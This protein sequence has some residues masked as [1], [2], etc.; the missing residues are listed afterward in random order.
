[1]V[2]DVEA[3]LRGRPALGDLD[4]ELVFGARRVEGGHN[5]CHFSGWS[6][7]SEGKVSDDERHECELRGET[8][9]QVCHCVK[10]V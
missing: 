10:G 3:V 2:G 5:S 4:F 1:M 8:K 9:S 7:D 6:R